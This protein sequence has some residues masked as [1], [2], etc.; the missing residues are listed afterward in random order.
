MLVVIVLQGAGLSHAIHVLVEHKAPV[1]QECKSSHC[2]HRR[3][4]R[5]AA[6]QNKLLNS[7]LKKSRTLYYSSAPKACPV[8][9][10]LAKLCATSEI[11]NVEISIGI[12]CVC[13]VAIFDN[14]PLNQIALTAI[15][16]RAPPMCSSL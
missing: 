7:K 13:K 14:F 1:R 12:A 2:V 6:K 15:S 8:C 16:P 3:D 4:C 5:H 9:Q 11:P 10:M